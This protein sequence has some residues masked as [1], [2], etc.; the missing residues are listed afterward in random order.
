MHLEF[1][2]GLLYGQ[3]I[4]EAA[5]TVS[6]FLNALCVIIISKTGCR[7]GPRQA[8]VARRSRQYPTTRAGSFPAPQRPVPLALRV[9]WP[10]ADADSEVRVPYIHRSGS[11]S[12]R[13]AIPNVYHHGQRV[14]DAP[15]TGSII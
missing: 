4:A 15:A 11:F 2:L 6:S 13:R 8:L 10:W 7:C 3:I 12:Q 1:V 14:I 5:S 9:S